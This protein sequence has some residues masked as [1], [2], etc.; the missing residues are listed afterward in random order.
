MYNIVNYVEDYGKNT[1]QQ[2]PFNKVDNL[3]LAEAT[4]LDYQGILPTLNSDSYAKPLH[5]VAEEYAVLLQNGHRKTDELVNKNGITLLEKMATAC[6]F[7]DIALS[8][9][10]AE[11][12]L[13]AEKQFAA[14]VYTLSDTVHYLAF[15][16]TDNTTVG[17]KEDFMSS[18][19]SPIPSQKDALTYLNTVFKQ[20]RGH[21]YVGGHSKGGNLAVYASVKTTLLNKKR[22]LQVY[23]NDGPG[24]PADFVESKKYMKMLPKITTIVP[25]FSIIGML[26]EQKGDFIVVDSNGLGFAQHSPYTWHVENNDFVRTE[27]R[28]TA[29][30]LNQAINNWMNQ[31]SL[32][33][34]EIFVDTI[35]DIFGSADGEELIVPFKESL[36]HLQKIKDRYQKIDPKAREEMQFIFDLLKQELKTTLQTS[37]K[38]V[39]SGSEQ[40]DSSNSLGASSTEALDET[41]TT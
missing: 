17:W 32:E 9:Y 15:R 19:L 25:E 35:F 23:N 13:S 26:L 41:K 24:F 27:L 40:D 3:I 33:K 1:F 8:C 16:G 7:K 18:Y 29:R 14:V 2:S 39:F 21:F 37:I 30:L 28:E 22:I 31:L 36:N 4:Y 10:R 38:S 12:D 6:R 34:R 20:L 11:T 5:Q